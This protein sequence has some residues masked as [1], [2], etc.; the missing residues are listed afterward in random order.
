VK[1]SDF[2]K[3][4]R[5]TTHITVPG[6]AVAQLERL[7]KEGTPVASLYEQQGTVLGEIPVEHLR[8]LV[9]GYRRWEP[10]K[11]RAVQLGRRLGSIERETI[12]QT[13]RV[14]QLDL[15]ERAL[16]L[17]QH[18]QVEAIDQPGVLAAALELWD[19]CCAEMRR[20]GRVVSRLSRDDHPS[21]DQYGDYINR[22]EE[23]A[24]LRGHRWLA[25]RRGEREGAL[26]LELLTDEVSLLD[27]VS[28]RR[29]RFGVAARDRTDQSL[30]QELVLDDLRS[31]MWADLDSWAHAEALR[32]ATEAYAGLLSARPLRGER[33]AGVFLGSPHQPVGAVILDGKG[34]VLDYVEA[35]GAG[36][37]WLDPVLGFLEA[38]RI[39]QLVVP[40][41]TRSSKRLAELQ[42][43]LQGETAV[44]SVRPTALAEGRRTLRGKEA[45]LSSAVASAVVLVRRALDPARAWG[46][47]DPVRAGVGEYQGDLDEEVLRQALLATKAVVMSK[48]KRGGGGAKSAPA[49]AP[50]VAKAK[51]LKPAVRT[52][53]ELRA[54]MTVS[55]QVT[56]IT[57]FG[58][59]VGLG[60]EYEGMV[61]I[62]E[63]SDEFVSNP[64][65]VV[66]IG[67]KVTAR[68]LNVD[69][70]R[71]RISLSM[72][73]KSDRDGRTPPK[74]S[75]PQRSQALR[76][77]ER[78]FSK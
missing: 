3:R 18:G 74:R 58:V 75:G 60:L 29:S 20:R 68:V 54:G 70:H 7:L 5:A 43:R 65:E 26:Q 72:R 24:D 50:V 9:E 31:A 6:K 16:R 19:A 47:I 67:D 55:G 13:T 64:N 4:D 45:E 8:D 59:F 53:S 62:S 40:A 27:Q 48:R 35:E 37:A 14:H 51:P 77:L 66:K 57:A 32:Q 36:P 78:L 12:S 34:A 69:S 44:V 23:L 73:Q 22:S 42:S 21:G 30:L 25:M 1:F 15:I 39:P 46:A 52:V 38:A 63:L 49:P 2:L 76:D 11:Q 28:L 41:G 33:V 61:H 10:W 71:R 17:C 56:N